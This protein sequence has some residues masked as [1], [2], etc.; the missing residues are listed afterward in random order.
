MKEMLAGARIEVAGYKKNPADFILWKPS[1]AGQPG[2]GQ[3]L[4]LRP[5]GLASG[6][7]G[8]EFKI[9]R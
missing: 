2:W 4:G 6:M 5:S 9:S 1:A 3:P 8:H 7:F